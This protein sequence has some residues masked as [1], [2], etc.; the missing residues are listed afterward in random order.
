MQNR[1]EETQFGTTPLLLSWANGS[2]VADPPPFVL[3]GTSLGRQASTNSHLRRI[4]AD[5]ALLPR[6]QSRGIIEDHST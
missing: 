3:P 5:A 1:P 4:A 6:V 2:A